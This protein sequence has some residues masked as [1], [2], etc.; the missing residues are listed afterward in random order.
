MAKKEETNSSLGVEGGGKMDYFF[1]LS[2]CMYVFSSFQR[3]K[4]NQKKVLVLM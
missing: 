1:W 3:V 4:V 2:N